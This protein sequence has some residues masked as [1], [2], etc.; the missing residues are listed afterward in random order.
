ME[1]RPTP[2][3][4]LAALVAANLVP[5]AGVLWWGWQVG[6]VV[7][8]Y[9]AESLILGAF[10]V[11][12]IL[13][14]EGDVEGSR[15]YVTFVFILGYGLLSWVY[16]S[17]LAHMFPPSGVASGSPGRV[18]RAM[19]QD[20]PMLLGMIAMVASHGYSFVANYWIGGERYVTTTG[21]VMGLPA[22]RLLI[23]HMFLFFGGMLLMEV[24]HYVPAL[25]SFAGSASAIAIFVA[26]KVFFDAHSHLQ[27]HRRAAGDAVSPE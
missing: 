25:A 18:L 15:L 24:R 7:M 14:A 27:E 8:L 13:G 2:W 3:S 26:I 23:T 17:F 22:R 9:W 4:S 5:L 11:L 12:R 16:G 6:D 1:V 10:C 21:Q 19:L 20:G